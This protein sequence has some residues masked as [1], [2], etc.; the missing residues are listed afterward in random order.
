MT[1][2]RLTTQYVQFDPQ[3]L[4]DAVE[5]VAEY[6]FHLNTLMDCELLYPDTP[7]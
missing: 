1:D 4:A 6:R 7:K 5:G 3:F 2:L